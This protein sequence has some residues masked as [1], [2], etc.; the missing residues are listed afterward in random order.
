MLEDLRRI[1]DKLEDTQSDTP[2]LE[3]RLLVGHALVA[4]AERI[5]ALHAELREV[6]SAEYGA[7]RVR[8]GGA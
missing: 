1:Y 8:V 6:V 3:A 7:L 4:V 2:E 5:E